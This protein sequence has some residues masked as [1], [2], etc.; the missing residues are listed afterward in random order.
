MLLVIDANI[1]FAA[2][3]KNGASREILLVSDNE[4][5][6]PEYSISEFLKHLKELSN[7]SKLPEEMLKAFAEELIAAAGIKLVPFED[8]KGCVDESS[9]LLPDKDDAPYFALALHLGCAIWSNDKML[10]KQGLVKIF[11]T[12]ELINENKC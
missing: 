3:I 2:L 1:L 11:S 4:F 7:K 9:E 6:A 10:K 5:Y 12:A 8:F